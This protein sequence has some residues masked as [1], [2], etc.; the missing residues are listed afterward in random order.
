MERKIAW[1]GALKKYLPQAIF[2]ALAAIDESIASV[3]E[4]IRLRTTRPLMVYTCGKGYCVSADGG[5]SDSNGLFV[6]EDDVEQTFN[7]L[8]GQSPYAYEDEIRQGFLTLSNGIRAGLAGS[9]LITGGNLRTYKTVSGINFRIPREAKGIAQELLRYISK[10]GSLQSTLIISPPRL[11]KTTLVRDIARCAGSG[12]G[13]KPS[14]V[15]VVDER[16]EIAA[17]VY[18]RPLFDVGRETDVVSGVLK[19]MGVFMALRSLSPDVI[20][21]DEIGRSDD[22]EALK[23]VANSGV[24]MIATAH[25][26]DFDSLQNKLFFK[27]ICDERMFDAYVVLSAALGR[28]TV[29]QIHDRL[30][31]E[32]LKNPLRLNASGAL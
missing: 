21:T 11:G 16:Q 14:R 10:E 31:Q 27:K 5:L 22:L 12:M 28:I 26:P 3:I 7:A 15:T 25:A 17:S 20:V 4:E 1:S 19:S 2:S 29:S 23:E 30:G 18:G 9:A 13:L 8:T 6:S 32:C 24:V